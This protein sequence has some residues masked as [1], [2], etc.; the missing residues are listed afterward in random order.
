MIVAAVLAIT[1]DP[2]MRLLFTHMRQYSFRPAWLGREGKP[3]TMRSNSDPATLAALLDGMA[4]VVEHGAV[5]EAALKLSDR[6]D[7]AFCFV[8]GGSEQAKVREFASR[9]AL[10][11]MKCLPYQPLSE[12][13]SSL[14]A[15][16]LHVVVM[17]EK[18]VGIVHPCKIYNI[19]SVGAPALYI[20]PTPSHVTDIASRQGKFFL[21]RH[22]DVEGVTAAITGQY[23]TDPIQASDSF[24]KQTLLPQ[25]IETIES[26]HDVQDFSGLHDE[27]HVNPANPVNPVGGSV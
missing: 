6:Q 13:S 18:F 15:A 3:Q 17:G 5:L 9:H 19:M 26:A 1:L 24:S 10:D 22:G 4:G 7:L 25:L 23:G 21:T 27:V 20:G 14:S 11:N 16:D 12:L 2:A 8:G